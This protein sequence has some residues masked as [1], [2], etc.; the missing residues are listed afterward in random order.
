[1]RGRP[2]LLTIF[3]WFRK[4]VPCNPCDWLARITQ[5]VQQAL[6][7][8]VRALNFIFFSVSKKI[9]RKEWKILLNCQQDHTK[10]KTIKNETNAQMLTRVI[11]SITTLEI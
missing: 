2:L 4:L 3:N 10:T 11:L 9:H 6:D 1:M 5:Q 7:F 8:I